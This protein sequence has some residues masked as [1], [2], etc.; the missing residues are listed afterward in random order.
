MAEFRSEF[1]Q[2]LMGENENSSEEQFWTNLREYLEEGGRETAAVETAPAPSARIGMF[3]PL[4]AP[5]LRG[6]ENLAMFLEQFYTWA[7]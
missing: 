7:R 4:S 2:Q 3:I 1:L 6:R 5:E